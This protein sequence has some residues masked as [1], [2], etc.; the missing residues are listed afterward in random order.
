MR[1]LH[2]AVNN[3]VATYL[4]RD[5]NIVCGNSDYQITFSFDSEWDAYEEKVARF[6]WNGQYIDVT[7]TGDTVPVPMVSKTNLL[8]IGVYAGELSTTTSADIPCVFSVL[9]EDVAE[10]NG[11]TPN[12]EGVVIDL[13]N[14]VPRTELQE[15]YYT[16]TEVD[17]A[18][19]NAITTTLNTGVDM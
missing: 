19:A 11:D 14:Y 17:D 1:N 10:G 16:K 6:I 12:T 5:G 15:G 2:I 18:I 13:A 9:C 4:S 7:F 3:K 8:K